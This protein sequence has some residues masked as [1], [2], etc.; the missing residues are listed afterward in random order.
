MKLKMKKLKYSQLVGA[1]E[2]CGIQKGDVVHVQSDLLRIGP[3]DCE[4]TR[5]KILEFYLAAFQEVLGPDGTL[6]VCTAFEDYARFGIPYI[7][8]ESPSLT[9][10]FSEYI[11]TRPLSI[12]SQHPIVSITAIGKKAQDICGGS[13]YNGFGYDSPWGYLHKE[14]AHIM[15]LGLGALLGGTTFFHY[16]EGLYGVPYKYTKI[17]ATPVFSK[18]N[19]VPGTFTMCVRY[20][21]FN[22]VNTPIRLKSHLVDKGLAVQ[23]SV[24]RGEIWSCRSQYIVD[25]AI[26]CLRHDRYFLLESPPQFRNGEIPMDGKTG[27]MQ[28]V[29]NRE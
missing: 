1:L 17:Y 29:Y 8:E 3:V 22:I 26:K 23:L 24:G 15:T 4:P 20:L 7:R 25:E 13:H 2:Q 19:I 12:R 14:N 11:R 21:D 9:D 6:T 16:V 5:E 28:V 27:P 18:G 10:S